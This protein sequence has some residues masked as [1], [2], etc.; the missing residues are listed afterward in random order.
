MK[1]CNRISRQRQ[2]GV[3]KIAHQANGE[4]FFNLLTGP[5]LLDIV[6]EQLPVHRERHYPPTL[7]LSMF[8]SQAMSAD[9]SCQRAVN[10]ANAS[11]VVCGL[12]PIS[13]NTGGYC[14]ARQRLP[15]E[16]VRKLV[17][18]TGNT[19]CT[20]LPQ[21]WQWCGRH[22]KLIDGTT[23]LMPDTE[24]N[25]TRYPQHGRQ[26]PGVGFP[27]ARLVGVISLATG[28]V[29]N[30]AMGPYKGKGTSELGLLRTVLESFEP[31]DVA[32]ADS[33]YCSYFLI[34]S[35]MAR[36]VDV[37][38][39]QH[40]VRKTDFRRGRR[41]GARD[42]V[43]HW[44]KPPRP[45][46]MSE[47]EYSYY[48]D[49]LRMREAKAGKK[50]LVT[51]LLSRRQASKKAL[52]ELYWQ[53]WHVEL[54]LR[55]IKATLGMDM[56]SCKT[57]AMCEKEIW[58][59]L[60]AYNLI[61]LLMAQAALQSG[62]APRQLSFKHTLQ[63]WRAWSQRQ[64]LTQDPEDRATLFALIAKI[65]VGNRPG[66]IEP[67]AVKRRPKPYLRL[68]RPRREERERIRNQGHGKKLCA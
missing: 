6:E 66:R 58:V 40:G 32:L 52:Q 15:V 9:G 25:Q 4:H 42:H 57:A 12:S 13:V 30:A 2:Q 63:L 31:G 67:R 48:P 45:F 5:E 65:R 28:V 35:L 55:N 59:Y 53:R 27:I 37:V 33:Y 44:S 41:L 16:M 11:R 38:F 54:D 50:V 61:R 29:L 60:L 7:T 47:D 62:V 56:L 46:W 68:M 36:G 22:V 3:A 39:E 20:Q 43:V 49:E 26:A 14:S 24:D 34:G 51:T 17:R 64:F 19:L 10:E 8:L 1:H 23:I 21:T 18:E